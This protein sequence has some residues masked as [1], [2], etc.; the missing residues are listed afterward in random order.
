MPRIRHNGSLPFKRFFLPILSALL[1][2]MVSFAPAYSEETGSSGLSIELNATQQDG[3]RCRL[4]FLAN[5]TTGKDIDSLSLETVL[6]DASGTFLRLTLFDFKALP[7]GRPR[8][9]QFAVP[10]T[11]CT[12]LGRILIN[13]TSVCKVAG[14]DATLCEKELKLET[15]TKLELI[16]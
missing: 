5:N 16:G 2:C 11:A 12:D 6:F 8:V 10:K 15:K 9:R 4:V 14:A 7:N 3:E 13:G 1:V